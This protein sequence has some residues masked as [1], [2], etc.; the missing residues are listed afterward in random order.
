[1]DRLG[2]KIG[3]IRREWLF[4]TPATGV[5]LVVFLT[6]TGGSAAWAD[7]ETGWSE[8][9]L[10]EGF[11][12]AIPEP[13]PP[14]PNAPPS[15]LANPPRWNDGSP[16]LFDSTEPDDV[17]F[18]GVVIDDA[19]ARFGVDARR[20]FLTGFSNGAGMTFRFAAERADRIAAIAPVAGHLWVTDPKPSRSVS[21]LYTAGTGDLL[22][23]FRGGE[24]RLPWSNRLVRRPPVADTLERWAL[25]IGCSPVP[26]LHESRPESPV[27]V[28]RYPGP[29]RFDAVTVEGLGHHWPGGR[30]QLNPRLAGPPSNALH[31]TEM[32]WKFFAASTD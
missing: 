13:L 11:A 21:T 6:G 25:A 9:A 2:S 32:I 23:P 3:E 20:V 28:D 18:L 30:A 16:P 12:L 8:L 27:R 19:V 31:A 10:R 29:V 4:V 22:L 26:V 15:F 24:V 5:P 1:M 7:R 14:D 17:A